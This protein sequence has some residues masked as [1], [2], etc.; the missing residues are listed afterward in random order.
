MS[1][2]IA[3]ACKATVLRSYGGVFVVEWYCWCLHGCC[4]VLLDVSR[5]LLPGA[6]VRWVW[7]WEGRGG[8]RKGERGREGGGR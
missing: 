6:L 2:T 1:V 7:L 5:V 4:V 3:L 8:G